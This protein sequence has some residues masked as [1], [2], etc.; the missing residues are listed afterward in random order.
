MR[1]EIKLELR[2]TI[3]CSSTVEDTTSAYI[4]SAEFRAIGIQQG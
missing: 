3:P 4:V 1:V 2:L